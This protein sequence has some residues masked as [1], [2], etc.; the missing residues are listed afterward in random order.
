MTFRQFLS[1]VQAGDHAVAYLSFEVFWAPLPDR[2]TGRP[3]PFQ[4]GDDTPIAYPVAPRPRIR[5]GQGL[6]ELGWV[7][8]ASPISPTRA[9][10]A[11][12]IQI[13]QADIPPPR[14]LSDRHP[15]RGPTKTT[16]RHLGV[17]D[18]IEMILNRPSGVEFLG[19][20]GAASQAF[21][22]LFDGRGQANGEHSLNTS[23]VRL[24]DHAG[25]RRG[26]TSSHSLRTLAAAAR[27]AG[28]PSNTIRPW[29]M[30]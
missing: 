18:V 29:P 20:T 11:S 30:T 9:G 26:Q 19:A 14:Y 5:T 2:K 12:R 27:S 4:A 13:F 25:P 6:S 28:V 17:L 16:Q 23:L 15:L 1:L 21:E 24:G 8:R 3:M 10:H 7:F 22:T